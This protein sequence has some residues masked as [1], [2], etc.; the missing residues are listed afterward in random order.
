[1]GAR[2]G[3]APR[4]TTRL[5]RQ[6]PARPDSGGAGRCCCEPVGV[7]RGRSRRHPP[8]R[9][10]RRRGRCAGSVCGQS[11]RPTATVTAP[12]QAAGAAIAAARRVC[13]SR[14]SKRASRSRAAGFDCPILVLSEQPP[15]EL[16]ERRTCRPRPDRLLDT[17]S[18][19][20]SPTPADARPSGPPE[21]RYGHAPGRRRGRTRPLALATAIAASPSSAAGRRVHAPRRRR[22]ARRPV[23]RCRR[24]NSFDDVA[25]GAGR[26]RPST[27]R[28][29]TRRTRR[30]RSP[31]RRARFDVV[32]AGIAIYGIS[33]GPALDGLAAA[34]RPALS[35][36]ARS[37]MSSGSAPATASRT[38]CATASSERPTV[39]TLPL[40]YADGVPRRLFA[41]GGEVLIGG[42]R[43]P[44]VGVVTMD[45]LMVDCG[46]R[47]RRRR[48]RGGAHRHPGRAKRSPPT[49]WA[50]R[51]GTI[52]YEV[53]L[54]DLGAHRPAIHAGVTL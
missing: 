19:R 13:V 47:R 38:A 30:R 6:R 28:W 46:R 14:W 9:R 29:C 42:R 27:R 1:M 36:R 22:R 3:G 51:L 39:A 26:G 21:D 48:R 20:P 4:A 35:L 10:G 40:G 50:D 54:R 18:C 41:A 33:P 12:S 44:I 15:A 37:R 25:H 45:Q 49:E 2:S 17:R 52:G 5:G 32:R 34:L 8:Q 31:F 53:R 11:S 16:A 43:T 24:S 7:G 23:H